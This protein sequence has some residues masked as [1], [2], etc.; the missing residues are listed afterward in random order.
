MQKHNVPFFICIDKIKTRKGLQR[1]CLTPLFKIGRKVHA[2]P[3]LNLPKL[4]HSCITHRISAV[5]CTQSRA[6]FRGQH[7]LSNRPWEKAPQ[8]NFNIYLADD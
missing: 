8:A 7:F 4:A 5:V 3:L 2:V 1:H 6:M